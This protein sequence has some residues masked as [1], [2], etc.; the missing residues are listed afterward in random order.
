[1]LF[2]EKDIEYDSNNGPSNKEI[3]NELLIDINEAKNK[4]GGF[5]K[6]DAAAE[7]LL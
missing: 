3:S 1:M 6:F 5:D 7:D 2:Q 4:S